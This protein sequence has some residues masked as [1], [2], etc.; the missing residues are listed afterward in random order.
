MP[1]KNYYICNYCGNKIER[2]EFKKCVAVKVYCGCGRY[3]HFCNDDCLINF[4]NIK[5][6]FIADEMGER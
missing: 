4:V 3:D 2:A 6:S 5:G 1:A